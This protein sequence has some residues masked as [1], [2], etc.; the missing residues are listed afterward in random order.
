MGRRKMFV[1]VLNPVQALNE[2]VALQCYA[3]DGGGHLSLGGRIHR[4]TLAG[5][6]SPNSFLAR[7]FHFLKM[8]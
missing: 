2:V 7:I 1:P 5:A 4:S 6:F 3:V 8:D